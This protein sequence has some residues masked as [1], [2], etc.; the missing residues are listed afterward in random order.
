LDRTYILSSA[1]TVGSS[2]EE[3]IFACRPRIDFGNSLFFIHFHVQLRTCQPLILLQNPDIPLP[4]L[5]HP[6]VVACS[7]LPNADNIQLLASNVPAKHPDHLQTLF[8]LTSTASQC[9]CELC[10]VLPS[11][12]LSFALAEHGKAQQVS[13][14]SG[15]G[16]LAIVIEHY[17]FFHRLH[18]LFPAQSHYH[19]STYLIKMQLAQQDSPL[20]QAQALIGA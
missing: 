11:V 4:T 18:P 2:N 19:C 6:L 16:L 7:W 14:F 17:Y 5:L 15:A 13:A 3:L 12:A 20:A 10:K 9:H 1:A 8:S